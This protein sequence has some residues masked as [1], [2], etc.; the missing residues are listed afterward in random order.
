MDIYLHCH[1]AD[2]A[3]PCLARVHPKTIPEKHRHLAVYMH[4]ISSEILSFLNIAQLV[5]F[6]LSLKY[7]GEN[8]IKRHPPIR[9]SS[10]WQI[11]Q[12]AF[13]NSPLV[14]NF[15]MDE[16]SGRQVL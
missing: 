3:D 16:I 11:L 6:G 10:T 13:A 9:L 14:L 12:L 4:I 8:I 5:P 2:K 1:S 15:E 7:W